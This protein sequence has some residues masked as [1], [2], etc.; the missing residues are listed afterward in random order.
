VEY[1]PPVVSIEA[2]GVGLGEVL[3]EI[4]AKV[5]FVVVDNGADRVI[6]ADVLIRNVSLDDALRQLLRGENHAV[7]YSRVA[8]DAPSGSG[9]S[10]IAQ[11]V[12]LGPSDS[13]LPEP[14]GAVSRV[15]MRPSP[16]SPAPM[17]PSSGVPGVMTSSAPGAE[18]APIT[19]ES[20]LKASATAGVPADMGAAARVSDN[21]S[22]P[23]ENL[24]AVLAET[25]RRAQQG[26][27]AL[28]DG[29]AAATASLRE[30]MA[31][32]GE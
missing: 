22:A 2:R 12:L 24:E 31:A 21:R 32:R 14:A 27:A 11:I 9:A 6:T 23:P 30:S 10:A 19:A 25:T 17:A 26:V 18:D 4:G 5:G 8:G 29:L 20:L 13:A 3:R 28:V 15:S 7:L 16:G 1:R